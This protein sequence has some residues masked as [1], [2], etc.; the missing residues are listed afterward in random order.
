MGFE[1]TSAEEYWNEQLE[2]NPILRAA[3]DSGSTA[4]RR[5]SLGATIRIAYLDGIM[6]GIK[7]QEHTTSEKLK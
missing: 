2:K 1:K 4:L 3:V 6:E 5:L 7:R